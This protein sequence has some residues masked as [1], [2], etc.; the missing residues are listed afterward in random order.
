MLSQLKGKA[1]KT[2]TIDE[3]RDGGFFLVRVEFRFYNIW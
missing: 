3:A 2:I 1:I